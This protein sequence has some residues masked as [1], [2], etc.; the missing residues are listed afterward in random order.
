MIFEFKRLAHLSFIAFLPLYPKGH[1]K[2]AEGSM[3]IPFNIDMSAIRG[4]HTENPFS[5]E[6]KNSVSSVPLW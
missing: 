5:V 2:D 1:N 4:G 3:N 6:Q